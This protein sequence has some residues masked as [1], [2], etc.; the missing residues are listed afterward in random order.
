MSHF[1]LVWVNIPLFFSVYVVP[2]RAEAVSEARVTDGQSLVRREVTLHT[3]SL[4]SVQA[5]GALTQVQDT[6]GE[7]DEGS[8]GHF[9]DTVPSEELAD[10]QGP[11]KHPVVILPARGDYG[12]P[13]RPGR[14]GES[15]EVGETGPQGFNGTDLYGLPGPQGDQGPEG[16]RGPMGSKGTPGREGPLGPPGPAPAEVQEIKDS[17]DEFNASFQAAQ[18]EAY[19]THRRLMRRLSAMQ[20]RLAAVSPKITRLA[21]F[22]E[23]LKAWACAVQGQF[24][25][26]L[27]RAGE[28]L[29]RTKEV[30]R[31]EASHTE[32]TTTSVNPNVVAANSIT[33]YK[34]FAWVSCPSGF[35]ASMCLALLL[36]G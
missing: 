34:S 3:P 8:E 2:S 23:G 4:L 1:P 19:S 7:P 10:N 33:G 32:I 11:E 28:L 14:R 30:G 20:M 29:T 26:S 31:H 18:E 15:G 6:S 9:T 27:A 5:D 22:S 35:V 21:N 36:S 17:F 25:N 24:K 12:L 13:G 16:P